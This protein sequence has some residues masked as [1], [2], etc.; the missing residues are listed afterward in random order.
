VTTDK[1]GPYLLVFDELFP[2]GAHVTER[3]FLARYCWL[4][5]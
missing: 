3:R 1:A 2:A 5:G 4:R